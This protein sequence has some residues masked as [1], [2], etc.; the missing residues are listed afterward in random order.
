MKILVIGAGAAGLMA[1]Y[2][3]SRKGVEVI[4]LES[5]SRIGGRVHTV[6]PAEF[7]RSVEAGAEFILGNLD[8]TLRLM[9]K[10][11]LKY[12]TASMDMMEFRNG[13]F[14]PAFASEHW[15]K[16]EKIVSRIRRDCTLAELLDR[17]FVGNQYDTFRKE[18]I[19]M[20]Q[21]LDLADPE[22]LSVFCIRDEWTS[23]EAQYR[24]VSGYSSLLEFLSDEILMNGGKIVFDSRVNAIEWTKGSVSAHSGPE[25]FTADSVIIT[26]TLGNLQQRQITFRPKI[27]DRHFFDI[28]F[29]EVI[30]VAMEFNAPFWEETQPDLGFLFTED[31]LTFWTQLELRRPMLIGWIGNDKAFEMS[32]LTDEEILQRLIIKLA[33]AFPDSDV[34]SKL[35]AKAVFR[36]TRD[37]P[38][39]G[40]YS[41]TTPKS[42]KAIQKINQGIDETIWFAGEAFERSGDVATVEAALK[43][44]RYIARKLLR[45]K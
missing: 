34:K 43:S 15:Q 18:C 11:K 12:V 27:D 24:P 6:T 20:A 4:V 5:D 38:S 28:G 42:R 25:I 21:G 9:K 26:A 35:R 31:E 39:S 14:T 29:G 41:W 32:A 36:Y 19:E 33:E 45:L 10:A 1:A 16:F 44:G 3:L 7:T 13:K 37:E 17:H 8:L 40:G 2:G 23:P 30:K 22:K